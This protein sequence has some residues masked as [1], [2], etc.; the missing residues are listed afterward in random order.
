MRRVRTVCAVLAFVLLGGLSGLAAQERTILIQ[1]GRVL[2]GTGNPWFLADVLI[3][4][5]R[6]E[7]VGDLSGVEADEVI[8]ATGL[9]VTPGFIDTHSHAGPALASPGLSHGEPLLAMGL[10]T[11]FANPDGGGSIDL[12]EQRERLLRDGI[13]VNVAQLIGHGSVRSAVMGSED[14]HA[15]ASELDRMR[16]MVRTAMEEGAWGLSSGTFYA[17]GNYAPPEELEELAKMVAPFGGAY[18]SHLRDEATYSVGLMAA[19]DEVIN[20]G[21]IAGVPVVLTHVKALGPFV[22]GY[23]AAIVER[24]KRARAEG[25]Q[26][27]ADQ[28][29]YTASATGLEPALLPRWSQ[30]G[31]RDSLMARMNDPQ[32][33]ARIREGMV[34][35]LARRGGA[36]RIQFRRYT[37]DESIEGRLL[38]DLAQERGQDPIDTAIDLMKAGSVGIVS[39]NMLD[40]DVETLMAQPWT[41]T[42]SDG[43]LVPMNEG[44]PHPRTYGAFARKIRVYV[45]E[46]G[47][48]SLEQAVRSMTSLPAQVFG[49]TDRGVLRPG[50][51]ADISVFDLAALRDVADFAD[52]HHYSE[53]MVHVF[54]NGEAAIRN[55]EFTGARPG[56]VLRKGANERPVS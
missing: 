20:V 38:S 2:D 8:D 47:T 53:G 16:R 30:A 49:M 50:M 56:R 42:A 7:A 43:G 13:G 33:M 28:Y 21:R 34:E 51:A 18:T 24:V 27:Y 41:M 10:T 25:I 48:V 54:V 44:V 40:A 39:Y 17:P 52:P 6:I 45:Q 11:I 29:P 55:G 22:W 26:V 14:R 37:A 31:G 36:T 9:Y 3:R 23:G 15:T 5:D 1:H 4:G 35:G 12:P 32:T 46:K 19:V